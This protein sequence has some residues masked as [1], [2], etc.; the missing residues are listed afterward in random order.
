M[1]K[2]ADATSQAPSEQCTDTLR[3]LKICRNPRCEAAFYDR[4]RNNG[5]VRHNVRVCGNAANLRN[6]RA[7]QRHL[8]PERFPA[9][10][11]SQLPAGLP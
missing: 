11:R 8:G 9:E 3:R 7:R 10:R 4:S 1:R 5:G 2:P 6:C